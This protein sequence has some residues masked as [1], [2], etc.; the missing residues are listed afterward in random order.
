M[1]DHIADAGKKADR[2]DV[3]GAVERVKGIRA[4][5]RQ[6]GSLCQFDSK[7]VILVGDAQAKD[8]AAIDAIL[9]DCERLLA[10]L[11]R[12]REAL[13]TTDAQH[14]AFKRLHS[15]TPGTA[16][17]RAAE[18]AFAKADDAMIAARAALQGEAEA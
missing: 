1:T 5:I 2:E 6:H 10:D 12:A 3:A 16:G 4:M 18:A 8:I 15:K 11:D 7:P 9:S 13:A 17:S 14:I